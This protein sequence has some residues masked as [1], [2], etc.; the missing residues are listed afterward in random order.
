MKTP[1]PA[2]RVQ[3]INEP[4]Y[5]FGSADNLRRYDTEVDLTDGYRPS[6]VHG[7]IVDGRPTLVIGDAGG[8]SGVHDHSLLILDSRAFVAVGAH[9]VC[10]TIGNLHPDWALKTDE[11]TCLGV[12][13]DREHDALIS[14][15][16]LTISRFSSDGEI[17]WSEGG[18]DIFSEGF[19]MLP[20]HIDAIDFD[21]RVYDFDYLT[22]E[23]NRHNRVPG[24]D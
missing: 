12:Y 1:D 11:A 16:E 15:G 17:I 7:V 21:H 5:S 3:I 23:S 24:S 19:S 2:S 18:A 9:V 22:G 14:H 4:S 20:E 6:S 13:Y 10:F 8:A